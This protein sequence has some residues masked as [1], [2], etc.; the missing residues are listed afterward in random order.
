MVRID[1]VDM[2]NGQEVANRL[3]GDRQGGIPWMVILDGKGKELI[4]SDGPNGNIG[5]P[6][7]PA[8]S[9]YFLTML[10]SSKDRMSADDLATVAQQ[11][12]EFAKPYR[13]R[14]Q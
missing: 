8:E 10:Q 4:S 6:V 12:E 7:M 3:R 14:Y 2:E 5:C 13:E 9:A 1:T 11:L